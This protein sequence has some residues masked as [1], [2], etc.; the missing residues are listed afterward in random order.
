MLKTPPFK[1]HG[2]CVRFIKV[3]CFDDTE[4]FTLEKI[5]CMRCKHYHVT[6]DPAAPRGC[7]LFQFKSAVMPH[8][9]VKQSTGSECKSFDEKV[10]KDNS[11]AGGNKDF[12]DPKYW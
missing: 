2:A 3:V 1:N 10:K 12:N 11:D 5:A 8:V 7:K 6:F 4:D 9:L